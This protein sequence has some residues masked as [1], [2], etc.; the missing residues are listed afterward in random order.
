MKRK[1]PALH[2]IGIDLDT[3]ALGVF[4]CSYPVALIHGDCASLLG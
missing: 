3:Q 2:D 1:P 4:E